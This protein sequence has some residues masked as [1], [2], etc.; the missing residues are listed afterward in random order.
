[1]SGDT[2]GRFSPDG[3][4]KAREGGLQELSRP[5]AVDLTADDLVARAFAI[6]AE[7]EDRWQSARSPQP[8]S[9]S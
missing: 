4:E 6:L 3:T 5:G 1:M 8:R 2:S 9:S 7:E